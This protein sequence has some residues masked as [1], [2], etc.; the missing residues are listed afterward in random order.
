MN[1]DTVALPVG[2]TGIRVVPRAGIR[3]RA[4]PPMPRVVILGP[5]MPELYS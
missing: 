1:K 3:E 4:V 2:F 5:A